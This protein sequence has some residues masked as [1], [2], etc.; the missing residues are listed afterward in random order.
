VSVDFSI[1]RDINFSSWENV[2]FLFFI[3]AIVIFIIAVLFI[4]AAKI[5][6]FFNRSSNIKSSNQIKVPEKTQGLMGAKKFE[7]A[8]RQQIKGGDFIKVDKKEEEIEKT[9]EEK[10]R[11]MIKAQKEKSEKNIAAAMAKLKPNKLSTKQS[12]ESKMPSRAGA[13]GQDFHE[14]IKISTSSNK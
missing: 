2:V 3:I 14:E 6:K 10:K 7:R 9:D 8:P 11:E 4:I 5:I 12:V 13:N 1:L